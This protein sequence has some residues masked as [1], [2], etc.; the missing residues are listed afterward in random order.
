MVTV[1][2]RKTDTI[3]APLLLTTAIAC[4]HRKCDHVSVGRGRTFDALGW[5]AGRTR[6][7]G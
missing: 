3:R 5:S 2:L 1:L 4:R 7:L 6:L